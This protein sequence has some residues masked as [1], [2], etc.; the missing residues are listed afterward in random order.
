M[1]EY[2]R[3]MD[4]F[5]CTGG[6]GGMAPPF[7]DIPT[8][9]HQAGYGAEAT[10]G[11]SFNLIPQAMATPTPTQMNFSANV[12]IAANV[13]LPMPSNWQQQQPMTP[14][15]SMSQPHFPS[16]TAAAYHTSSAPIEPPAG[17]PLKTEEVVSS[18]VAGSPAESKDEETPTLSPSSYFWN[19]VT[20]PSCSDASGTCQCGDGCACVGCLTHG[21]HTGEQL[22]DMTTVFGPSLGAV[23]MNDPADFIHFTAGPA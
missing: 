12:G 10:Q 19:Q 22:E 20:L 17:T 9:P 4:Q 13:P 15:T 18:P 23:N 2:I 3:V 5:Q 1:M 7:Y 6:F 16:N 8:Y 11:M 21:G 14:M